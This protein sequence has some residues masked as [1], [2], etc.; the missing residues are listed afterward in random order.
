MRGDSSYC[1]VVL[2]KNYWFHFQRN[3]LN[4]HPIPLGR[5]DVPVPTINGQFGVRCDECGEG[6]LYVR[7][8]VWRD[9]QELPAVFRPHPLFVIGGERRR[10]KRWSSEVM[11]RVLGQSR[12]IVFEEEVLATSLSEQGA[13]IGLSANVR[14]GQMLILKNPRTQKELVSRVVRLE[15]RTARPHVGVEFLRP[16]ADFWPLEPRIERESARTQEKVWSG[17]GVECPALA[18]RLL[19]W[20]RSGSH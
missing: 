1:W 7:S 12:K 5:A 4:S 8:D 10:S 13:Q 20:L 9:E 2:C 14:I 16:A 17:V 15:R 19:V 3:P 6:H 18:A 11:L